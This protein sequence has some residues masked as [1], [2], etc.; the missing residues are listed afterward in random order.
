MTPPDRLTELRRQ[1]A[2]LQQHT[3]WLDRE[4]A[5]ASLD[6]SQPIAPA[7]TPANPDLAAPLRAPEPLVTADPDAIL[8][9]YRSDE[10]RLKTDVRKG[11]LLYSVGAFALLGL[12]VVTAYYLLTG[13]K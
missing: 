11:C 7:V 4:I 2:L 6:A 3:D 10:G 5:A 12:G 13:S 1:R 9:Q 8:S